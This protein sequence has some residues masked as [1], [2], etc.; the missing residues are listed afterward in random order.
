MIPNL[1][2]KSIVSDHLGPLEKEGEG[3]VDTSVDT[4]IEKA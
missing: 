1:V 2:Q 3:D 4:S